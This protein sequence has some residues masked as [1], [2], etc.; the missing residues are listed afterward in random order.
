MGMRPCPTTMSVLLSFPLCTVPC[1]VARP[2][3]VPPFVGC[4]SKPLGQCVGLHDLCM[5]S[6]AY[7]LPFCRG[8]TQTSWTAR[9]AARPCTMPQCTGTRMWCAC[10]FPG[11]RA[12]Q[13]SSGRCWNV[14]AGAP[15]LTWQCSL[16]W[17][18][19]R[20]CFLWWHLVRQ[21]SLWWHLPR[22][23]FLWWHLPRQCFL[24][25]HLARQCSL[26]WHLARQ[27][28]LWWHLARQCS[29]W[30]HLARQCFLWW[31]LA[32]QCSLWWHLAR[33]CSLWW[34]LPRQCFLWWHLARQC[35]LWWHL[36]RH[37]HGSQVPRNAE[38]MQSGHG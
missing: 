1:S 17:H 21:C 14:F 27:C 22:Q 36:A 4:R 18:L 23:C 3:A 10:C 7:V 19:P 9:W 32:R 24:W 30:W 35:S 12:W 11:R 26:W 2:A 20:Q 25:W 13:M 37:V 38:L 5:G 6:Q 15:W 16:W 8:R 31:H 29:L 33:Q 34:H 28:S